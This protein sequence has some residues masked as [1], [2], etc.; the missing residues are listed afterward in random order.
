VGVE[1]WCRQARH[2]SPCTVV[3]S[4]DVPWLIR[5][6]LAPWCSLPRCP[7]TAR[8]L[9]SGVRC[10]LCALPR[11]SPA[12]RK[13][14]LSTIPHH[15]APLR[16]PPPSPSPRP[17]PSLPTAARFTPGARATLPRARGASRR[18]GAGATHATPWT[19]RRCG[20]APK[21]PLFF[22]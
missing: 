8:P 3:T 10:P 5:S 9:W 2:L 18:I 20:L 12:V 6:D 15:P 7:R 1:C 14:D 17:Q 13:M 11:C 21:S 22:C 16:L 19:R 4:C